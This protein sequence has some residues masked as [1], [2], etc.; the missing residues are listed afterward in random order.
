MLGS[1]SENCSLAFIGLESQGWSK[2]HMSLIQRVANPTPYSRIGLE[3]K[4]EETSKA[5]F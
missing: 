4:C 2:G 5:C 1:F 3:V